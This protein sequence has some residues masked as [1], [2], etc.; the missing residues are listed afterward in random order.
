LGQA[1]QRN[2]QFDEAVGALFIY[3][4]NN[5]GDITAML[6]LAT[7][8]NGAGDYQ[9]AIILL[10][11]VITI[12]KKQAEAYYQR[13]LAYMGLEEFKKA[14]DE[15]RF[16]T[17]YDPNDFDAYIGLAQAYIKMGNPGD[18]YQLIKDRITKLAQSDRQIAEIY[19]WQ[20]IALDGLENASAVSFWQ[21]LLDLPEDVMPAEWRIQAQDRI[22]VLITRTPTPAFTITPTR[23]LTL[24]KT[25]TKTPSKT[26]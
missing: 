10:N 24:A 2:G 15:F 8:Y 7:G 25:P 17:A 12:D 11:D 3:N 14:A 13:G 21:K 9:K 18:A 4:F 6:S 1:Y 16:A 22:A 26:P 23:T 5:P 20:A 19:Y